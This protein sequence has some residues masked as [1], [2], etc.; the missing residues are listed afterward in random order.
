MDV[1]A[2]MIPGITFHTGIGISLL[3]DSGAALL[4]IPMALIA[5]SLGVVELILFAINSF[6]I[7]IVIQALG[8]AAEHEFSK[9]VERGESQGDGIVSNSLRRVS[10][11][12]ELEALSEEPSTLFEEAFWQ[13]CRKRFSISDESLAGENARQ[14]WR[15]IFAYLSASPY[16]LTVRYRALNSMCRGLWV[17]FGILFFYFLGMVVIV[18]LTE[19]PDQGIN[20]LTG[21]AVISGGLMVAFGNVKNEFKRMFLNNLMWEFYLAQ[22]EDSSE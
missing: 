9:V 11:R 13:N 3:T 17:A 5:D 22:T 15:L 18:E 19:V 12:R 1:F 8:G 21:C 2:N 4:P 7:G 10:M 20:T 6:I 14:L 16:S